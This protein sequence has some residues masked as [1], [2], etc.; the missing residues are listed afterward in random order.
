MSWNITEGSVLALA[1]LNK[2]LFLLNIIKFYMHYI[3]TIFL[4]CRCM[5]VLKPQ[6]K[7]YLKTLL[8]PY[9][10]TLRVCICAHCS[11]K[12]FV[13]SENLRNV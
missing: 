6:K 11:A 9:I 7:L 10:S 3:K 8:L 1:S 2:T 13:I 12:I 4:S 5:N